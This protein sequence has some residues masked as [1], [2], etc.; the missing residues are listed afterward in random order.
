MKKFLSFYGSR[1]GRVA[2]FGLILLLPTQALAG[3]NVFKL[4]EDIEI[5]GF[6]SS[7]YS[8]NFNNPST[9]ANALRIFDTDDNSFKF[10]VG[11]LV[12]LKD[13]TD[14]GDI[15]FRF[16]LTFGF[17]VPQVEQQGASSPTLGAAGHDD[18]D[19]Q[20]GFVSYVAPVGNGLKIDFGKFITHIGAE[21]IEGYDGWNS[22]FS[23]SFLF[24][25]AIPFVHTGVRAS[26][27]IDDKLSVMVA[28]VN[29]IAPGETDTNSSKALGLQVGYA[30]KDNISILLNWIG[31]GGN[32]GGL[33]APGFDNEK[34]LQI[35]DVVVD[36]S[37]NDKLSLQF[38]VD[39]GMEE[40]TS[41]KGDGSSSKWWGW[42]TIARY[43]VNKWF[44]MN[45]RAEYFNDTDGWGTKTVGTNL[46][47][48]T[49][50]P[51]FRIHENFVFRVEYRHDDASNLVFDGRSGA[52][53]EDSQDTIAFN[54]LVYF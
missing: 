50:T 25:L 52:G 32:E 1:L 18:F 22:N 46:W 6:A 38:N 41:L 30:P 4:M 47:E 45:V 27:S 53:T 26:Y 19:V 54:A 24:G 49:L 36:F 11:E 10:D 40:N 33:T 43:D 39:Y 44:S 42:A 17:S 51:E 28:L 37:V 20:Q 34:F 23:R 31:G 15:G 13:A 16:D 2:L 21:V 35:W 3:K 5:H 8:Y 48:F 9:G 29:G 14:I 12:F 7:S